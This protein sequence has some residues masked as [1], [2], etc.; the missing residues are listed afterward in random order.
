MFKSKLAIS[1][2]AVMAAAVLYSSQANAVSYNPASAGYPGITVTAGFVNSWYVPDGSVESPADNAPADVEAFVES[3][4]ILGASV[5]STGCREGLGGTGPRTADK[6]TGEIFAIKLSTGG[7]LVYQYAA[8][9]ALGTFTISLPG[10]ASD[11]VLNTVDT[12]NSTPSPVPVPGAA[13]LL[14]SGLAGLGAVAR[15]KK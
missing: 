15:K 1:A 2:S 13:I 8:A 10:N 5:D 4:P 14:V 11:G 9:L 12:F 7:Y 3:A 6:C